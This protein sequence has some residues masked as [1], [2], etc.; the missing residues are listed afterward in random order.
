MKCDTFSLLLHRGY[1]S[2]HIQC[3]VVVLVSVCGCVCVCN[4]KSMYPSMHYTHF[5]CN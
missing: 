3:H 1:Q 2:I 5:N 4:Y